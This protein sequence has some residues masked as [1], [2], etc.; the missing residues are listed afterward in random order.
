MHAN[1][2]FCAGEREQFSRD[3]AASCGWVRADKLQGIQIDFRLETLKWIATSAVWW[4]GLSCFRQLYNIAFK[5]SWDFGNRTASE[6]YKWYLLKEY[7]GTALF[8]V[9]NLTHV[10][11]EP[12]P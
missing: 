9:A 1:I 11:L 2:I 3:L 10:S 7:A 8:F 6:L 5:G 12:N 4:S